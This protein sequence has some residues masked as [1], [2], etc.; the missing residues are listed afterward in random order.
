MTQPAV[1]LIA[2]TLPAGLPHPGDD[3]TPPRLIPLPGFRATGM[4][5]EQAQELVGQSS[6]LVA[7]ALVHLLR[8]NGIAVDR[9]ETEFVELE[10][11]AADAPDGARII[12]ICTAPASDPVLQLTVSKSDDRVVVPAVVLK[13]VGES[14]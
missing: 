9:T 1:D 2:R 6:K 12:S 8:S 3:N 7:E 13:K 11:Q 10:K 5:D 14:L 4:S